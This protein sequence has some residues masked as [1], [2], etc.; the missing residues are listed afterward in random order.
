MVRVIQ[1]SPKAV[2]R[3]TKFKD[4]NF[5]QKQYPEEQNLIAFKSLG[6]NRVA[7]KPVFTY[8]SV[9]LTAFGS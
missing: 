6:Y 1:P 8:V 7:E 9:N 4:N 5:G 2:S 3:G